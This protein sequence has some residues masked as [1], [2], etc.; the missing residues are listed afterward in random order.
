MK[1]R[2]GNSTKVQSKPQNT[3]KTLLRLLKYMKSNIP[4]LIVVFFC[5]LISSITTVAGSYM[6]KPIINNYIIPLIGNK[7][8]DLSQFINLLIMMAI[9]Y[10]I[11]TICSYL[12]SRIMLKIS[13]KTLFEIRLQLFNHMEYLNIKYFDTHSHGETMSLFTNDT[14]TLRDLM[15]QVLPHFISSLVT[16]ISVFIMMLRLSPV[17]TFLV[18]LMVVLMIFITKKIGSISSKVF[19]QQQ[20][21][22]GNLNGYIEEMTEGL[23]VVKV[24]CREEEV[25]KNFNKLNDILCDRGTKAQTLGNILGPTMNNLSHISYALTAIAG[26]FLV[27]LKYLD[28]GSIAVFLQY[29]RNFS[30]PVG[31]ISQMFN[32]VLNALAGA[33]RIFNFLDV[34]QETDN[35]LACLSDKPNGHIIFNNVTFGYR[36][37]KTVLHNISFEA[38]PGKKIALVGSTGS[39]KTTIINLL[40]RF[41]DVQQCSGLITYDGIPINDIPKKELRN[42]IGMVLQDTHLFSG[43]IS[44]N[45]RYGKLDATE[46]EVKNAAILANADEF[47]NHLK[48]GYDTY[49][50]ED[51]ASLSQGQRQLLAIAR[52]A[53]LNPKVLILDEATS[54]IDS[55]TEMLISKGMDSLMQG[56]TTFVIAHRLSTIRNADIILVLEKGTIIEKGSHEELLKLQGKYYQL[57]N[58]MLEL[59]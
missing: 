53:I 18:L 38:L 55:R 59:D 4:L 10:G 9:I 5:V 34:Q 50:V 33:E 23:K 56:R 11:G 46:Q 14:D 58:G 43:T 47:I 44:D 16:I 17:L 57:Y 26:S 8:P 13:T 2:T 32:N 19:K 54:S 6:L 39:G 20:Q 36:E 52:T 30:Q 51:G 25:I 22:I 41:Y 35:G 3:L 1:P 31:Q 21:S 15:S 40:T 42:S 49:I 45:I 48:N 24:F 7:N 29:T 12:N 28:V 27:I 37:D